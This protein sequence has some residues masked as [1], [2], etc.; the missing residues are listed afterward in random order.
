MAFSLGSPLSGGYVY[1]G[2]TFVPGAQS[3]ATT[4]TGRSTTLAAQAFGITAS[5]PDGPRTAHYGTVLGGVLAAGL[6]VFIWWSLP[7]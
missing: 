4:Q 1:R 7:R 3:A 2:P 6:L 5:P